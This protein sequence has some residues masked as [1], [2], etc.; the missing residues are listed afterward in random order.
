MKTIFPLFFLLLFFSCSKPEKAKL[1]VEND[2]IFADNEDLFQ[3]ELLIKYGL[4]LDTVV[5]K[6]HESAKSDIFYLNIHD[7]ENTALGAI[8]SILD[9][10]FNGRLLELIQNGERLIHFK[11]NEKSYTFDPNRIFSPQGVK[12]TL[13]KNGD[14]SKEAFDIVSKFSDFIVKKLLRDAQIVVAL[15][16]NSD[17]DYSILDY[18]EGKNLENQALQVHINPRQD[19]DD[20]LYVTEINLFNLYKEKGYNVLLQNNKTVVDDGSLSVYCGLK[21]IKYISIEV[22]HGHLSENKDM[23]K[24]TNQ[25]LSDMLDNRQLADSKAQSNTQG[26]LASK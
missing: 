13:K 22:Q 25:I 23:I 26:S 3:E 5:F 17:N 11:L 16:N 9:I 4:A 20:F 7:D 21:G 24:Y 1:V 2:F 12:K 18:T 10:N 8:E 6:F 15:H 19:S 14:Y